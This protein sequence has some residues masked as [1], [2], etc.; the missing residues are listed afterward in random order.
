VFN[1][2]EDGVVKRDRMIFFRWDL[3]DYE[4][5]L[6][7]ATDVSVDWS[8]KS[9]DYTE[10][11]PKFA[12][13]I[14]NNV[15]DTWKN[16]TLTYNIAVNSGMRTDPGIYT[17]NNLTL[18]KEMSIKDPGLLGAFK[19]ALAQNPE[20]SVISAKMTGETWEPIVIRSNSRTYDLKITYY[21]RDVEE[22][23]D[24][25]LGEKFDNMP[26]NAV[27][28][29]DID[30]VVADLDLPGEI[31]GSEIT[32]TSDDESVIVASSG[33]VITGDTAKT[34]NL[35]ASVGDKTKTFAVTVPAKDIVVKSTTVRSNG[36]ACN[37]NTTEAHVY[38]N[39][40]VEG[41]PDVIVATYQN[42]ELV[43]IRLHENSA[44]KA[45]FNCFY[46]DLHS[47]EPSNIVTKVIVLDDMGTLKP[48]AVAK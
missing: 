25:F 4:D 34:V 23:A 32:W 27:S 28:F 46:S 18:V 8:N 6:D 21:P 9:G 31:Y 42:D 35:T 30:N 3:T 10:G 47:L 45:G 1:K 11:E 22:K 15:N 36:M 48:L 13:T 38:A 14:M 24:A 26:W 40:D 39:E 44:I 43:N 37:G 12:F 41:T 16:S 5:I 7:V 29:Q 17:V 20:N 33:E 2:D 19:T